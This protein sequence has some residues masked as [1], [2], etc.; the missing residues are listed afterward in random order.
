MA[1]RFDHELDDALNLYLDGRLSGAELEAFERRMQTDPSLRRAIEFHRGLTLEFREEDPPL[2]PG[3]AARARARLQATGTAHAGWWS[4]LASL[5]ILGTAAA[6]IAL[7]VVLWPLAQRRM[8]DAGW[9]APASAPAGEEEARQGVDEYRAGEA[10]EPDEETLDALRSLGYIASG[11][12][13]TEAV[14]SAGDELKEGRRRDESR[15]E[16]ARD[17]GKIEAR[18]EPAAKEA[19]MRR[20]SAV[21]MADARA[22]SNMLARESAPPVGTG[23]AF[24]IVSVAKGPE[25]GRNHEVIETARVWRTLFEAS[26][27]EPPAVDF[28][29]ER[30]VLLRDGLG[31]ER[32]ARLRVLSVTSSS[33]MLSIICR[34]ESVPA[35]EEEVPTA[36]QAVVLPASDLPIRIVVQ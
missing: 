19:E 12:E 26:G 33:S 2:P 15:S 9:I 20:Q 7:A 30:A 24:R 28:R 3:F 27:E 23:P 10:P 21:T 8:S 16:P 22:T 14:D 32:T 11:K 13:V 18:A 1:E 25:L 35:G 6:V 29:T 36:G 34:V 4:N 17:K 31:S 5:R